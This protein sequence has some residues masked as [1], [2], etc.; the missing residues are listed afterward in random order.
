MTLRFYRIICIFAILGLMVSSCSL[1]SS[2][3]RGS[4]ST[5]YGSLSDPNM[6]NSSRMYGSDEPGGIVVH[7]NSQLRYNRDLSMKVGNVPG[8]AA[9]IVMLTERNAYAA[10]LIRNSAHSTWGVNTKRET[11]NTGTDIGTYDPITFNQAVEN[12]RLATGVNNYQTVQ[13]HENINSAFK[14]NIAQTIR[15]ANP[16]IHNVFISANRDFINQLNAYAIESDWGNA[17]LNGRLNEFNG[18]V[19]RMFGISTGAKEK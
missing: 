4:R 1:A 9:A 12:W 10:V 6:R 7:N 18:T 11:N 17:S 19:N 3:K 5:N 13:K 16:T 8:V 14:Q 15:A 2:G